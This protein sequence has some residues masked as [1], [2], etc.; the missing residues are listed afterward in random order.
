MKST[1][2][3]K[4]CLMAVLPRSQTSKYIVLTATDNAT[5]FLDN[6]S[7][8]EEVLEQQIHWVPFERIIFS[9][10]LNYE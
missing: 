4:R 1:F 10:F 9:Q 3:G 8:W 2:V 7:T 5:D 6:N